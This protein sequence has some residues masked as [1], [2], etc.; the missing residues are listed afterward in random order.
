MTYHVITIFPEMLRSY[1]SESIIGSAIKSGVINVETYALREYTLDKHR[2][3][4][5]RPYGG[6]PGMVMWI[7]PI[8]NAVEKTKTNIENKYQKELAEY[9]DYKESVKTKS[10]L[11]PTLSQGEGVA[12]GTNTPSPWERGLGGEAKVSRPR[13]PKI[14][15]VH[16]D[17]KGERFTNVIAKDISTKYT[18]IIFICGRYEGVDYRVSEIYKGVNISIGDYILTGGELPAMIMIDAISRNIKGV[19]NKEE[20]IEENRISSNRVYA[21]PEIY[22][23]KNKNYKVPEVLLS[24]NHALINKWRL[25]PEIK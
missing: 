22:K 1:L 10:G 2:R 4:D 9:R 3:V 12:A 23:Y 8:V 7:D 11:T 25:K 18:D 14:L 24:G 13:K 19:L 17:T 15:F 5:G 6:G 21:R 20:S 16:F